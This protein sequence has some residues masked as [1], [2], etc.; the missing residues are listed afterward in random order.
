MK[1]TLGCNGITIVIHDHRFECAV[2]EVTCARACVREKDRA[3]VY[4]MPSSIHLASFSASTIFRSSVQS[5]IGSSRSIILAR[6]VTGSI[7][8]ESLFKSASDVLSILSAGCH[9][10]AHSSPS[11]K[12]NQ[13]LP[14]LF[15]DFSVVLRVGFIGI[16]RI[17]LSV[18][19]M[20]RSK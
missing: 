13:N 14:V 2:A 6:P 20:L 10:T 8:H 17:L 1:N 7:L 4:L 15:T 12:R 19:I 18:S 9:L 16:R 11:P 3:F 5:F